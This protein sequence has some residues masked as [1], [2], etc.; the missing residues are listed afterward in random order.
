[1][2]ILLVEQNYDFARSLADQYLRHGARARSS[3]RGRRARDMDRDGVRAALLR[4]HD[5]AMRLAD[6]ATDGCRLAARARAR[7][8]SAA[9]ARTVLAERAHDGPLRVQK[10]LYPEG[11]RRLPR[12]RAAPA[13]RHRRRR[14]ARD[15]RRARAPGAR[16]AHHAGRG[17]VVSQPRRTARQRADDARGRGGAVLEW[18]PQETIVFDGARA[19]HRLRGASSRR[20]AR[21]IGW[22]IAVPRPHRLRASASHAASCAARARASS[23]TAACCGSSAACV[24][25]AARPAASRRRG[26]RGSR[27][28]GDAAVPPR[29]ADGRRAARRLP[30]ARRRR[31]GRARAVTLLPG[32]LVARYLGGRRAR[33]R[34][35]ASR[36]CGG[37][38]ARRWLGREAPRSPRIWRT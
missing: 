7:V 3:R 21:F 9:A 29:A 14:R 5:G 17:Q 2:A 11:R 10:A 36:A 15:R 26:S 24:G 30:R 12:D 20:D 33:P 16:A 13:G 31:R 4:R 8:R 18:L 1:M 19:R 37:C 35:R 23:A 28:V 32:V 34:A 22:E 6:D 25:R 27:V 38:C